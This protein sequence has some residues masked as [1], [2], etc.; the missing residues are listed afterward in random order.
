MFVAHGFVERKYSTVNVKGYFDSGY[1]HFHISFN[2]K[3]LA[4]WKSLGYPSLP[5]PT[6]GIL[7]HWGCLILIK[8]YLYGIGLVEN[9]GNCDFIH[10]ILASYISFIS[11]GYVLKPLPLQ[12]FLKI[13]EYLSSYFRRSNHSDSQSCARRFDQICSL[14]PSSM[15]FLAVIHSTGPHVIRTVSVRV[16][17]C[18]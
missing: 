3:I 10:V 1:H 11:R 14:F 9:L 18:L 2:F 8:L 7:N 5:S 17:C 15:C 13:K 12:I 6:K 16:L 4:S